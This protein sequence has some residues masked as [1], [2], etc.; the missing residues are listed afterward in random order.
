MVSCVSVC[1]NCHGVVTELEA[2]FCPACGRELESGPPSQ[3]GTGT[4]LSVG[5]G[6]V[7][8]GEVIGEGGMGIVRKGWLRY[9]PGGSRSGTPD[10]PVAVKILNPLLR[11]RERARRLFVGEGVALDRV[12][13]PNIVHFFGMTD[14]QGQ[15]ALVMEWVEGRPLSEVI[16]NYVRERSPSGLPCMPMAPAWHNFS[17]LLGAL[18]AIHALGIV[19]R[20]VKPSNILVRVDAMAK[21]T[22]FGIARVPASAARLSGGLA[23]GT[24]AYMSPEQ[25]TASHIDARSDLYS[26]A[27]VLFEMLTGRTPFENLGRSELA[28]RTAQLEEPP[29]ALTTLVRQAPPILDL[30]MARALAKDPMHRFPNAI[31]FGEALRQS[32]G[33]PDSPGWQAQRRLA[34]AAARLSRAA[35]TT[36]DRTADDEEAL[37]L[38]TDV[39][40]AYGS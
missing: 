19:H 35:S 7:V 11:G 4:V 27:I 31:E 28:I 24:G 18:A 34:G 9:A 22:D 15:L 38:R 3:L 2:R 37:R 30:L 16:H 26:A 12:S 33:L 17:Q 6:E 32:L 21:L 40:Q 20:D 8:L 1:P 39:M 10:H 29:P 13:H 14:H 25:V 36:P 5:Y 23:P